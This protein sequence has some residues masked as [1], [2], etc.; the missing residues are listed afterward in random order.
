MHLWTH[1]LF[2]V[3]ANYSKRPAEISPS[4]GSTGYAIRLSDAHLVTSWRRDIVEDSADTA[5]VS[6]AQ[7]C[8]L[9]LYQDCWRI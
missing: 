1:H 9:R 6:P 8:S 7:V 2:P 3:F 5:L 4:S